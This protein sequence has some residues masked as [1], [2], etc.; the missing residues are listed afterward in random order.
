MTVTRALARPMMAGMFVVG[1]ID[2]LR[3]PASKVP[4]AEDVAPK[5]AEPLG[6]PSD[7][8]T[9]VRINGGV[10]VV[11][12]SLM[13]L[14]KLPRLSALAL[15]ASL[16]PTTYAGHRF[17]E[18]T[19]ERQR[20]QQQIQFMKNVSMLGGLIMAAADTGGR[21]SVTWRAKRAAKKASKAAGD[22]GRSAAK[23]TSD[24]VAGA[25][26]VKRRAAKAVRKTS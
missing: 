2:A 17:W 21:P 22:A 5:L 4:T 19:D 16:G 3:N 6:L 25:A 1:G 10:Q 26:T 24:A 18:E 7:P 20:T 9:L 14:G 12:G 15:A 13:A 23:L 8:V 11:A